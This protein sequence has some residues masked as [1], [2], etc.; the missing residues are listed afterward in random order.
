METVD[1]DYI[2]A[3]LSGKRGEQA[4]LAEAM[5]IDNDKM[6]RILAGKRRVQPEEIPRVI[7][8]FDD[9]QEPTDPDFVALRNLWHQLTPEV[10]QFLRKSA[11]A[12]SVEPDQVDQPA[13]SKD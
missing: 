10:R 9:D 2:V 13:T 1:K 12:Q 5:G 11:Q 7:Q 8:F 6:S 4:R 3:R